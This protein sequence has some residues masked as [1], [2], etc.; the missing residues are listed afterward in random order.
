MR[1][2]PVCYPFVMKL[3]SGIFSLNCNDYTVE[4]EFITDELSVYIKRSKN[5][6][7]TDFDSTILNLK[8]RSFY[9]HLTLIINQC[10]GRKYSLYTRSHLQ[11]FPLVNLGKILH[12]LRE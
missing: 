11:S 4:L 7:T 12:H 10:L 1:I 9:E 2:A 3:C 8:F 6:K 5:M